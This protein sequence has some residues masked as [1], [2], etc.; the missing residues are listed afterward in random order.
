[1]RN[2]SASERGFSLIEL[3]VVVAILTLVM[4]V[5]FAAIANVQKRYRTEEGRVDT[6][7]NAREFVDQIGRDIHNTGYPTARMYTATPADSSLTFAKGLS[8]VSKT[9]IWFE[10]DLDN[11]GQVSSVRYRLQADSNGKCPCVLRRASIGKT[12]VAPTSQPVSGSY[13]AEVEGVVNSIGG[14]TPWGVTGTAP[15]GTANDT[16]YASY[17]VDPVFSYLDKDG[18]AVTVPDDLSTANLTSGASAA[19]NVAVIVVTL[20]VLGPNA[21]LDTGRRP[22]ATM[23]STL[24]VPNK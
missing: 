21:D 12:A 4:G 19:S 17:R 13:S 11:S 10:G 2:S 8:A 7:Q 9:D 18:A 23:R 24:K 22:V 6:M 15:N 16:V 5:V 1:M 3:M 20:N 14:S